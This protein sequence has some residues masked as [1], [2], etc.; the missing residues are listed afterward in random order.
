MIDQ[1]RATS[2][3]LRKRGKKGGGGKRAEEKELCKSRLARAEK[4]VGLK[5]RPG[6]EKKVV[7]VSVVGG[8]SLLSPRGD[9]KERKGRKKIET[10][11]W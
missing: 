4:V 5:G 9:R 7:L 11:L 8:G 2:L 6:K 10:L 1:V 3:L